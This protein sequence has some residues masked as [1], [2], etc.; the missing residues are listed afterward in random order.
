MDG[1]SGWGEAGLCF[2][3]VPIGPES[4]SPG[5]GDPLGGWRILTA[6]CARVIL[7]VLGAASQTHQGPA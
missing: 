4:C 1:G 6:A 2:P 7:A 3:R 5:Q